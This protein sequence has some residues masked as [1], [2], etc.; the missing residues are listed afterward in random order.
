[1]VSIA[2]TFFILL[3]KSM[4]AA[5]FDVKIDLVGKDTKKQ[6]LDANA[7]THTH[8]HKHRIDIREV[9]S[10]FCKRWLDE[11]LN[12]SIHSCQF[13]NLDSVKTFKNKN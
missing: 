9:M 6:M 4:L 5:L 10:G 11:N 13:Q 2:S 8:T 3:W 12:R 7:L 1:M